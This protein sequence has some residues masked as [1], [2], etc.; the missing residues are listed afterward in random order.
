MTIDQLVSELAKEK[1]DG[2]TS[3][4]PCRVVMVKNVQQYS[5]LLSKLNK[6]PDIATVPSG[7][8]FSSADVMPRYENL[9]D[10]KYWDRWLVLPGV[11]EYLRL[12]SKSEAESQRFAKLWSNQV[13]ATSRGRIII[14]LWGCEAQWHDKS[15]HLCED[16]RQEEF[17]YDCCDENED[18][19]QL[20]L[21]VLSGEFEQY[22]FQLST[23]HGHMCIGL[24]EWYEYWAEPF[25][26]RDN[27]ILLTKRYSSIQP[28]AGSISIRVIRD[29]FSFIRESLVGAHVLTEENCPKQAQSFLF[30]SALHGG[31]LDQAILAALNVATFAGIDIMSKWSSLD[32]GEKQLVVLWLKLHPDDTYLCHCVTGAPSLD[33]I[34][35]HVLHDVFAVYNTH[36]QWIAESQKLIDSMGLQRDEQYF[37]SLDTVPVYEDRLMFLSGKAKDDRIYLLR[38]VG[39]WMRE[40]S[41]QVHASKKLRQVYPELYAYLDSGV[42]DS[43]L[44]RYFSLYKSHK[45]ENT[46]P[47]DEELY[48]SGIEIDAYDYRYSLLSNAITD[49][50]V[51]LWIDALGVEWLPLL[52]WTLKQ[53]DSGSIQ[54]L[55]VAQATL[56]TETC[57]NDQWNQMETPHKKL[58]RLDKL[59]HKGVVDA[60]DYYTCIEDQLSFISGLSKTVQGLLKE[61][62]RVI[63]TGDHGTSRLAAR[64]FHNREGASVPHGATVCS[65]GRY[66]M[67]PENAQ[68]L[69]PNVLFVKDKDGN[70]YAVF[71]NYDHFVQSGFAAG[72]DDENAIYGEVHG[73]ASP[74]EALV[75]VIVFDSNKE[76]PLT[77]SW[78]STTVK[79]MAKKAKAML[80]FNRPIN[81]LQVRVGSVDG[82]C[83]PSFDKK[84]WTVVLQGVSPNTYSASVAANGALVHVDQLTILSALGGGDG[85]L[86]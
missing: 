46:L 31:T 74:E 59:A 21:V 52:T 47:S 40:D 32:L 68:V 10:A 67:L 83:T 82:I 42:Y 8:L 33:R 58:D 13:P 11:S 86:P 6:I 28:T 75:P 73:G 72:G 54:E 37:N 7:D 26:I 1:Q 27:Q 44:G 45:L 76:L 70:K 84:S 20:N 22:I 65:H 15:L 81:S 56:P 64:F 71:S 57:F 62:H 25:R 16:I 51:V 63:I 66:C 41:M 61:Y 43:D 79:I 34:P 30:D 50:C 18:E 17:Y 9:K 60:P 39:K 77:A 53:I 85:D 48:F 69:H 12:F 80:N 19:Q 23:Q 5:E 78:Q 38:L 14:P 3:R 36:S 35:D 55:S 49:S 29:S 2:I 24:Q 4:F